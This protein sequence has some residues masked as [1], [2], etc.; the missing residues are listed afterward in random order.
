MATITATQEQHELSVLGAGSRDH[1]TTFAHPDGS[2]STSPG[3]SFQSHVR[4][5]HP[6]GHTTYREGNW[7]PRRVNWERFKCIQSPK[8]STLATR[9]S[10]YMVI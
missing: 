1:L 2:C 5:S 8:L 6:L 9:A 10:Q 3:V 4:Q 7:M